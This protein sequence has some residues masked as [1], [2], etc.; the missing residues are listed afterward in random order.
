MTNVGNCQT[1]NQLMTLPG[2]P[3]RVNMFCLMHDTCHINL[4][5]SIIIT[6]PSL[7]IPSIK[8]HTV[9]VSPYEL[10]RSRSLNLLRNEMSFKIFA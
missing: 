5:E 7:S 2:A 3:N 10:E 1:S 9:P 4:Q 6:N 8:H